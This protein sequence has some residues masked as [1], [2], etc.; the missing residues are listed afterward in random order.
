[1]L[2]LIVARWDSSK[3]QLHPKTPP[4]PTATANQTTAIR[5]HPTRPDPEKMES[6]GTEREKE[7]TPQECT[8]TQTWRPP[9]PS[10]LLRC[11]S[12]PPVWPR[13]PHAD[14]SISDISLRP[15]PTSASTSRAASGNVLCKYSDPGLGRWSAAQRAVSTATRTAG[16]RRPAGASSAPPDQRCGP[17]GGK[18]CC[19]SPAPSTLMDGEH[20]APSSS[21]PYDQC[22][23]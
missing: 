2:N 19:S 1:M 8:N 3:L 7:N 11:Y 18:A 5:A 10:A 12:L 4:P 9:R 21:F 20:F 6:K 23:F 13:P 22:C 17:E 16:P 14:H 15:P